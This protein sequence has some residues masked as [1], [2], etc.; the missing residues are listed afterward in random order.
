MT[1]KLNWKEHSDHYTE[2]EFKYFFQAMDAIKY[3]QE[4]GKYNNFELVEV[5][6]KK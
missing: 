6:D 5:T 4:F 1:W 3:L 2:L